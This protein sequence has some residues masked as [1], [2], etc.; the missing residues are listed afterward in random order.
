MP[1]RHTWNKPNPVTT[2]LCTETSFQW[3]AGTDTHRTRAAMRH[4]PRIAAQTPGEKPSTLHPEVWRNG[5]WHG[6]PSLSSLSHTAKEKGH[7]P[8]HMWTFNRHCWKIRFLPCWLMGEVGC[9][10]CRPK[11]QGFRGQV[12]KTQSPRL[13]ETEAI[14]RARWKKSLR[15]RPPRCLGSQ[16]KGRQR[17]RETEMETEA[18]R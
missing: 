3:E 16:E 17:E 15:R 1:T 18:Q 13:P 12:G 14:L 6:P 5:P 11:L 10:F 9:T 4:P 7:L 8:V 2:V